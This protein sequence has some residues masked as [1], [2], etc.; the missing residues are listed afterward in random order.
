MTDKETFNTYSSSGIAYAGDLIFVENS[1]CD[2]EFACGID[3]LNYNGDFSGIFSVDGAQCH[4]I[5]AG[6]DCDHPVALNSDSRLR[7]EGDWAGGNRVVPV[8]TRGTFPPGKSTQ[9]C[10]EHAIAHRP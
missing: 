3:G 7:E 10:R 2:G 8:N 4:G 6:I 5:V 9:S 1:G